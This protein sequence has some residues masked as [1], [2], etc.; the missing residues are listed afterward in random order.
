VDI[1]GNLLSCA[2]IIGRNNIRFHRP[3]KAALKQRVDIL[4]PVLAAD[5]K[6][7][8]AAC[9]RRAVLRMNAAM[10]AGD[11]GAAEIRMVWSQFLRDDPR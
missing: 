5:D 2:L 10:V 1:A 4:A 9:L 8:G 11:R 3:L 7:H 6:R